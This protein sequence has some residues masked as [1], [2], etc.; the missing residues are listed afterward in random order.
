MSLRANGRA[1]AITCQPIS[2]RRAMAGMAALGIF[3]LTPRT[4]DAAVRVPVLEDT[5]L[6]LATF[7]ALEFVTA[8]DNGAC[9]VLRVEVDDV[10]ADQVHLGE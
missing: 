2:R 1:S 3:A 5:N 10:V 4:V 6:P 7:R 9:L 8:V